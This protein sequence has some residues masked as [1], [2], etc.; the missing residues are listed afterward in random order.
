MSLTDHVQISI[1]VDNAGITRAGFGVPLVVSHN[2]S[3]T[4]RVRFY[5]TLT[6]VATDFVATSP[7]YLQAVALLSQSPSPP[8]I[9]IGRAANKPTQAYQVSVLAVR[10]SYKYQLRVK[11]QGVTATAVEYTSDATAT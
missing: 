5:S 4:E 7:E 1:T 9:A 2:A 3:W 11:G 8:K 10:N 6:D